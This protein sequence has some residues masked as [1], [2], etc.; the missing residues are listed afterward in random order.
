VFGLQRSQQCVDVNPVDVGPRA[1]FVDAQVADVAQQ[2]VQVIETA[3]APTLGREPL[4]LQF[5]RGQRIGIDEF[6]ELV[7]AVQLAQQVAVEREGDGAPLGEGCVAL[8]HVRRD[9]AE[10]QR[11]GE[12]RRPRRVDGDGANRA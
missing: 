12:R 7:G 3:D 2:V 11:L 10:Q 8:V 6:A 5:E 9:P 1:H 4:Q